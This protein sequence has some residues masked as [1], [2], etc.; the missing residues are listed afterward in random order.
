MDNDHDRKN[1]STD[2]LFGP[3]WRDELDNVEDDWI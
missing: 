2:E 1:L 3:N